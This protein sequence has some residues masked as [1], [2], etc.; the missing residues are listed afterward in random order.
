MN[1]K[2]QD[3]I[4]YNVYYP[5]D[6]ANCIAMDQQLFRIIV[7]V[8]LL[9]LY[10]IQVASASQFACESSCCQNYTSSKLFC[11]SYSTRTLVAL[12]L[13]CVCCCS[14]KFRQ[15]LLYNSRLLSFVYTFKGLSVHLSVLTRLLVCLLCRLCICDTRCNFWLVLMC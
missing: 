15:Q 5:K 2:L 12:S 9:W 8:D 4:A 7:V 6:I 13:S 11:P 1:I 3:I 14:D 10:S